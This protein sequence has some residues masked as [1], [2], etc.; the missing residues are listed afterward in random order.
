MN[1]HTCPPR[2]H[3]RTHMNRTK[4]ID[5]NT[6][7]HTQMRNTLSLSVICFRIQLEEKITHAHF[8]GNINVLL[9]FR[10]IFGDSMKSNLSRW[11]YIGKRQSSQNNAFLLSRDFLHFDSSSE[12]GSK[13][14]SVLKTGFSLCVCVRV[15]VFVKRIL[16]LVSCLNEGNTSFFFPVCVWTEETTLSL[17]LP[18]LRRISFNLRLFA[19]FHCVYFFF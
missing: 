17:K 12:C 5:K 9:C 3:T 7:T 6:H 19:A 18:K 1:T 2:T 16:D 13:K 8:I 14:R 15:C 4:K 11:F 10:R